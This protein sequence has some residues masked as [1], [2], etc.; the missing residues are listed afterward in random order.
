MIYMIGVMILVCGLINVWAT[1]A[2]DEGNLPKAL[3][4]Y[5]VSSICI[6]WI[7]TE[8][9]VTGLS[10][11]CIL[12]SILIVS[13]IYLK[14]R[15]YL[16]MKKCSN[17]FTAFIMKNKENDL[18]F[19]IDKF[20]QLMSD[21]NGLQNMIK[22]HPEI[23]NQEFVDNYHLAHTH[24]LEMAY[25]CGMWCVKKIDLDDTQLSSYLDKCSIYS[26]DIFY[27]LQ[28]SGFHNLCVQLKMH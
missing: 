21:T 27:V 19:S 8:K 16:D 13:V 23:F 5:T 10:A 20:T 25:Y 3:V 2:V 4:G 1:D 6:F 12:F 14:C 24:G 15:A 11:I 7:Y 17:K 26:D 22:E 9:K 18:I 28:N